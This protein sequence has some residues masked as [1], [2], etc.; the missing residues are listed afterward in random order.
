MQRSRLEFT[1]NDE[2]NYTRKTTIEFKDTNGVWHTQSFREDNDKIPKELALAELAASKARLESQKL[3][4][5]INVLK[6]KQQAVDQLEGYIRQ[7]LNTIQSVDGEDVSVLPGG[8]EGF[9]DIEMKKL[10][11]FVV[12]EKAKIDSMLDPEI[13][14]VQNQIDALMGV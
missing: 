2:G 11:A 12:S 10:D 1:L 5:A 4:L 14:F 13:A 3:N 7:N 8:P 6:G 9:R